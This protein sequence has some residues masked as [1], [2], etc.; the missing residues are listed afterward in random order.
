VLVFRSMLKNMAR[1][2]GKTVTAGPERLSTQ[3][4]HACRLPRE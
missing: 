1:A 2:T 3:E 4:A